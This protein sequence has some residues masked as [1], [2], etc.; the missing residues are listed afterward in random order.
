[1][2]ASVFSRGWSSQAA[3]LIGE[4][5][6]APRVYRGVTLQVKALASLDLEQVKLEAWRQRSSPASFNPGQNL[7][8][9]PFDPKTTRCLKTALQPVAKMLNLKV[10][11][12]QKDKVI[13]LSAVRS[14]WK[15]DKKASKAWA[16]AAR[17]P[18]KMALIETDFDEEFDDDFIAAQRDDEEMLQLFISEL[19]ADEILAQTNHHD[20]TDE[21]LGTAT[22]STPDVNSI[23][24]KVNKLSQKSR[25]QEL[26]LRELFYT[27]GSSSIGGPAVTSF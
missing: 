20:S 17:R 1:M 12:D 7:I 6:C 8:L 22:S 3:A 21:H 5:E 26:S 23:N 19:S 25:E 9:K 14:C 10:G 27:I 15:D 2:A 18:R 16:A 4:I 13:R 11:F 24:Q